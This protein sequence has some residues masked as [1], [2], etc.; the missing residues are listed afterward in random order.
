MPFLIVESDWRAT[1]PYLMPTFPPI[2]SNQN[3]KI[4]ISFNV[5]ESSGNYVFEDDNPPTPLR[6]MVISYALG[7]YKIFIEGVVIETSKKAHL[8]GYSKQ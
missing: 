1:N 3:F 6:A 7:A 2:T 8:I 5:V 4:A